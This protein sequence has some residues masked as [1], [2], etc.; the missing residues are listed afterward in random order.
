MDE[1]WKT[2]RSCMLQLRAPVEAIDLIDAE[3][4]TSQ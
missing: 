4:Q 2:R 1:E 3:K